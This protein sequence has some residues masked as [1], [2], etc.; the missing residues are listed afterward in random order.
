MGHFG[1]R[2]IRVAWLAVV[3][4]SLLLNYL[5]QGALLLRHGADSRVV[6]NPFFSMVP[7]WLLTPLMIIAVS[8]AVIASQ[9]LISGAFSLT[10]Q[11]VQLGYWPRVAIV[12]TSGETEGQIY[13][14]EINHALMAACLALVVGFRHSSRLAAA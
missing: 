14:P 1:R 12:H 3:M 8:A 4:P 10:M 13:V 7:E 9:T 6:K 2:P 5:G 11:A